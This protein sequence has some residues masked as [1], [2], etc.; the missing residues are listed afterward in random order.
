M[1]VAGFWDSITNR[2]VDV[3]HLLADFLAHVQRVAG[4]A[5]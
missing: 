4:A 1:R 3:N 5:Q 2:F